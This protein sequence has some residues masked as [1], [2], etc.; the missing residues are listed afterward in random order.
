MLRYSWE[1]GAD[2]EISYSNCYFWNFAAY[3]NRGF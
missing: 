2:I 3:F 1:G